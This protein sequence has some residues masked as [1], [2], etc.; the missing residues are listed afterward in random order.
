FVRSWPKHP[1]HPEPE[2]RL[3]NVE[4]AESTLDM[5][6]LYGRTRLLLVP[7]VWEESTSR[8]VAE[9]QLRGIPTVASDRGG[10]RE[11]VGP[12]GLVLS[13]GEPIE[14]W[15]AAV[16]SMFADARKYATLSRCAKQ[17]ARRPEMSPRKAVASFYRFIGARR[18]QR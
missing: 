2:V 18:P 17:H 10:L 4:W 5:R 14:R 7:S 15:C 1:D 11:S 12:G 9:A 3:A 13:L 6:P 16:E 8:A